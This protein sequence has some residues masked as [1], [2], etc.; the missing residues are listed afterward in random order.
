MST[1]ALLEKVKAFVET[2]DD[3]AIER[4]EEFLTEEHDIPDQDAELPLHVKRSIEWGL[5][6]AQAGKGISHQEFVE[7]HMRWSAK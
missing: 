7:K 2:A 3:D 5:Q 4:L 6:D 1:E